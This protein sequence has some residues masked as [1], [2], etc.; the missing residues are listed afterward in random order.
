MQCLIML[1]YV[2]L[3]RGLLEKLRKNIDRIWEKE[4]NIS[5]YIDKKISG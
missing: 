3:Y 1:F 5:N 4:Y 2:E